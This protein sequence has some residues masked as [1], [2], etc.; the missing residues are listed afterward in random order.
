MP[1]PRLIAIDLDGDTIL[2]PRAEVEA[3]R[4]VAVA[5]LLARNRFEPC[6][7]AAR[8]AEGPYRASLAIKDGRL[9]IGVADEHGRP[10]ET[11]LL[12]M[13]RFRR[14][15]RDYTAI[16]DSFLALA[17]NGNPAQIEPVDMARRALHDEAA[18]LLVECLSGKITVDFD[19]ARRLFTLVAALHPR[20]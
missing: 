6:R 15:V 10:L 9:A 14:T 1:D 3:E 17:A 5:D 2:S 16:R 7:A 8:G 19:T 13:S 11:V 20:G 12:G 4:Q 18:Q